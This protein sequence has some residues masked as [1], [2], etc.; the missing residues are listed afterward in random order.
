MRSADNEAKGIARM[1]WPGKGR[2]CLLAGLMWV[3][4]IGT[5]AAQEAGGRITLYETSAN[6]YRELAGKASGER[7][8]CLLTWA[9]YYDSLAA[10]LRSG[11]PPLARPNQD[12]EC[13]KVSSTAGTEQAAQSAP[14][15]I[16]ARSPA[17]EL[18]DGLRYDMVQAASGAKDPPPEIRTKLDALDLIL[19]D[20]TAA[21]PE[22]RARYLEEFLTASAPVVSALPSHPY[23]V[24]LLSLRTAAF[25]ELNR[26][27]AGRVSARQLFEAGGAK[28]E[29]ATLRQFMATLERQGW[30]AQGGAPARAAGPSA[31]NPPAATPVATPASAP[32]ARDLSSLAGSVWSGTLVAQFRNRK[33]AAR[34][35]MDIHFAEGGGG[36]AIYRNFNPVLAWT[37]SGSQAAVKMELVAGCILSLDLVTEDG[38]LSGVGNWNNIPRDDACVKAAGGIPSG[39]TPFTRQLA[40]PRE[41]SATR[42]AF[43]PKGVRP[44]ADKP[45]GTPR[46]GPVAVSRVAP[47]YPPKAEQ[48][49]LEGWV[50]VL[51][52]VAAD[53]RVKDAVVR[54]STSNLF[55]EAA[56]TAVSQ[57]QYKPPTNKKGV[58]TDRPGVSVVITFKIPD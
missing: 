35:D 11:S 41:F 12:S 2:G 47:V 44:V 18:F 40:V 31:A 38:A 10:G 34:Y 26:V 42:I 37:Q 21:A 36:K 28:G 23:K 53:G 43:A 52:T 15:P 19:N 54:E 55:D 49:S 46:N 17:A 16:P 32:T 25:Q 29:G 27:D 3:P 13:K 48:L 14:S 8:N 39:S 50:V 33:E 6:Q 45:A 51:F 30:L 9:A 56:L 7:R 4:L 22:R 5:L 24:G 57:W 58:P 1:T 20:I